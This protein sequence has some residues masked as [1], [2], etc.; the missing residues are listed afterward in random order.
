MSFIV[1]LLIREA[2]KF[3]T[4]SKLQNFLLIKYYLIKDFTNHRA[5]Y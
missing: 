2:T 3:M 1:D 4:Q 5:L